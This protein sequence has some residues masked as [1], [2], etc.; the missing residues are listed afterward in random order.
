MALRP[1]RGAEAIAGRLSRRRLSPGTAAR[2]RTA[3]SPW[4]ARCWGWASGCPPSRP[5][6]K[7]GG[8]ADRGCCSGAFSSP[9]W[10]ACP[11][12][13]SGRSAATI[14][15]FLASG[16]AID[17]LADLGEYF[18]QA[19][20][21]TGKG[22]AVTLTRAAV[23]VLVVVNLVLLVEVGLWV[24]DG[25]RGAGR[26]LRRS[27][28]DDRQP[29]LRPGAGP[30]RLAAAG[31]V[32]RG[33]QLPLA[34]GRPQP[35]RG[36]GPAS[37]R[38]A[39]L[40]HGERPASGRWPCWPASSG[41][42]GPAHAGR[43][44]GRRRPRRSP[45]C[46]G[47][48]RKAGEQRTVS[49]RPLAGRLDRTAD[50]L[51]RAAGSRAVRLVP[52]G[53]RRLRRPTKDD[54]LRVLGGLDDRLTLLEE[55]LPHGEGEP[56]AAPS[57]DFKK[58]LQQS[59]G[60]RPA[61]QPGGRGGTAE[62]G[63]QSDDDKEDGQPDQ[64]KDKKP[65]D[66]KKDD[67]RT[68]PGDRRGRPAHEGPGSV[69]GCGQAALMLA[70]GLMLAV[71]LV[72]VVM[73]IASRKKGPAPAAPEAVVPAKT[74]QQDD[75]PREALLIERPRRTAAR[76]RRAGRK[77]KTPGGGG[78]GS[79][80]RCCRCCTGGSCSLRADAHERRIRPAGAAGAVGAARAAR[81]LRG[82]H[83]LVRAEMVRRP[84]LRRRG[85][86]AP[87][88]SW[89]RISGAGARGV[90]PVPHGSNPASFR[91]TSVLTTGSRADVLLA[92][93]GDAGR[94]YFSSVSLRMKRTV[95]SPKAA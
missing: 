81:R 66:G 69:P 68:S 26:R 10:R 24:L 31:P 34:R 94:M 23:L 12:C 64:P 70:A 84:R 83:R 65:D 42:A 15:A 79:T 1:G 92:A 19:G 55:T 35:A 72:G 9:P 29:G 63:E 49:R 91:S 17:S 47:R 8:T 44:L 54:A 36:A 58:R 33:V 27:A 11:A 59:G 74:V 52:Q 86:P 18:R 76:G 32:L 93:A 41:C 75:R 48:P 67:P 73:F 4:S 78:A 88:A 50:R 38:A 87:P 6:G 28:T 85:V 53:D 95:P 3:P 20:A 21:D 2:R 30:G 61:V 57:D 43:D 71:L 16:K 45:G 56:Q 51:E 89:P 14:H 80:W 22:G 25:T 90:A 60:R 13:C 39:R 40:P 7:A 77:D 5:H 37:A 46:A 62:G 82:V